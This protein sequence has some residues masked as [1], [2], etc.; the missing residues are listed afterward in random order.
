M[1]VKDGEQFQLEFLG[2]SS[3]SAIDRIVQPYI[4]N[5][6]RLGIDASFNRVD[7]SQYTNR[8]RDF[9]FDMIYDGYTNGLSEALGISQRYGSEDAEYSVFNP[10]GYGTEAVDLLIEDIVDAV[11]LDEMKT[12]IRAVDRLLR[13]AQFIVPTWFLDNYWVAH[14]D[15]FEHPENLPPYALGQLDFWWY[16]EEKA[17]ALKAAG[18]F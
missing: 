2:N 17:E 5:L 11:T 14:Y 18:A 6:K 7:P 9:D 1:L 12:G 15:M 10:A 4:E 8:E 13:H 3:N 16:N